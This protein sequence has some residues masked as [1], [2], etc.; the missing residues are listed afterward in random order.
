MNCP[1]ILT[2]RQGY[3]IDL[4]APGARVQDLTVEGVPGDLVT[5]EPTIDDHGNVVV[6]VS[7]PHGTPPGDFLGQ[8]RIFKIN[9][10]LSDTSFDRAVPVLVSYI[11]AAPSG[12]P[13]SPNG[14]H[15]APIGSDD[16]AGVLDSPFASFQHAASVAGAGDTIYLRN[17]GNKAPG[18]GRDPS[19][20]ERPLESGVTVVCPDNMP[21]TLAMELD[22]GGD[23]TLE[24]LDLAGPRL[25]IAAPG[26]HVT[27]KQVTAEHGITISQD[28]RSAPGSTSTRLDLT[29]GTAVSST[30]AFGNDP[31]LLVEAD[32]AAVTLSNNTTGVNMNDFA[33]NI[34]AVRFKGARQTL[35]ILDAAHVQ[36]NVKGALA[37]HIVG[38]TNLLVDSGARFIS[39][40]TIEGAGSVATFQNVSFASAPLAFQG[41]ELKLLSNTNFSNSLITFSGRKLSI[42]DTEIDGQGVEQT[43]A[44]GAAPGDAVIGTSNFSSAHYTFGAGTL[45]I[46][47]GTTFT[48]TPLK[49]QGQA[50]SIVDAAFNGQ[51]IEQDHLESTS[52][53][54]NVSITGYTQF[55]YHLLMGKVDITAGA[56]V[57]DPTVAASVDGR[58]PPWALLVEAAGDSDSSVTAHG[59]LFDG[60]PA[61][62]SVCMCVGPKSSG[63]VLS[64]TTDVPVSLCR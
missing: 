52:S 19:P 18:P 39:P 44:A 16:N 53:L 38:S 55:G 46:Q 42:F 10:R 23:A 61:P 35:Q 40:I 14:S 6:R 43:A 56:F 11:T 9:T 47:D 57:H 63:A 22:L 27:L 33:A 21:V 62:D 48:D 12:T 17:Y 45:T 20:L 36:N 64:V 58:S 15:D 5:A 24:N 7:A 50:L 51:G 32:G 34:D 59:T 28:A 26:S 8:P 2:V 1:A 37:I 41:D 54:K 31:P 4:P 30:A 49:F 13:T 3:H 29:S 60:A 25:V